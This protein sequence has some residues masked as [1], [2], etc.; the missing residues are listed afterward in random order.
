MPALHP[1][2]VFQT[3]ACTSPMATRH[4]ILQNGVTDS[5]GWQ[6]KLRRSWMIFAYTS[7]LGFLFLTI[8]LMTGATKTEVTAGQRMVNL[9]LTSEVCWQQCSKTQLCD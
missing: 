2:L 8:S 3:T 1:T 5:E 7:C 6:M 4:W 9:S